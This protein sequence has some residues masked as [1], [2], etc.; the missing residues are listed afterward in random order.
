MRRR[1]EGVYPVLVEIEF[2]D[3]SRTIE[4][5]DGRDRWI[6]YA[7]ERATRVTRVRVDPSHDLVLDIDRTNNSWLH[8]S[9]ADAASTK[10]ASKWML[11]V[12]ASMEAFASFS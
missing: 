12:Q 1:G 11:W 8:E 5:W 6:R 4:K 7:Y 10:W 9:Q 2:E 3:G